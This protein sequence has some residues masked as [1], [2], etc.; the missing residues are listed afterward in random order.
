MIERIWQGLV[1]EHGNETNAGRVL[2]QSHIDLE[3]DC[4]RLRREAIELRAAIKLLK[5]GV[6]WG[7]IRM[8]H[9]GKSILP[10]DPPPPSALD[11]A[12]PVKEACPNG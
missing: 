1:S 12:D 3:L 2:V 7:K 10:M 11:V 8:A 5:P 6:S 4:E 9:V